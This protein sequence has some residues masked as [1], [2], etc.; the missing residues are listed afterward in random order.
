MMSDPIQCPKCRCE[1]VVPNGVSF[2]RE[3]FAQERSRAEAV[4]ANASACWLP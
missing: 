2:A 3:M 4:K 1:F